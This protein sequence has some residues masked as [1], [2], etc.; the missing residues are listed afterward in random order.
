MSGPN[1]P[2]ADTETDMTKNAS[3]NA[4]SSHVSTTHEGEKPMKTTKTNTHAHASTNATNHE[5]EKPMKTKTIHPSID[6]TPA[7]GETTMTDTQPKTTAASATSSTTPAPTTAA[8]TT[9]YLATCLALMKQFDAA[10]PQT[11]P[12]TAKDKKHT[13]KARKG[14]ERYTPQLVALARD[15]GVSIASVP[16]DE[17]QNAS[18]EAEQLVPLQKLID[19]MGARVKTR[20]FSAQSTAWSGSSKMYAVL[21]RLSRDDGEIATG[22]QPV[23]QYFNHRHPDVAKNHPKTAKGKAALKA[24]KEAE[25]SAAGTPVATAAPPTPV[26][27][28][29]PVESVPTPAPVPPVSSAT[30]GAAHS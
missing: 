28:P 17:I 1:E 7:T 3:T 24:Q 10:F 22:L 13:A 21:K 15:H 6:A 16:L 20:M 26:T 12:L 19:R 9:G 14:S 8:S 23:E 30:N 29:P 2:D 4:S 27:Q 25:A 5:G 11:D 18:A